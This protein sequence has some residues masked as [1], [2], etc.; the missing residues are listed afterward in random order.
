MPIYLDSTV[1]NVV[2]RV[3]TTYYGKYRGTVA[4][5]SDPEDLCRIRANVPA[6][7]HDQISPWAMPALPFAGPGHGVVMLPKV[8]DGVW[9]EF[10]AGDLRFPIWSGCWFA[11]AQ[12]PDPKGER[13]RVIVSDRGH[14]VVLD[15]EDNKIVVEHAGGPEITLSG[16]SIV[17]KVGT[18]ELKLTKTEILLNRG[19]VKVTAAGVSLARGAMKIGA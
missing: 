8:G 1:A 5:I 14:K 2:E 12:R 9:I 13:V 19:M 3:T 4:D 18:S 16:S 6:V 11:N 10:E 7:L 17:M 15:D